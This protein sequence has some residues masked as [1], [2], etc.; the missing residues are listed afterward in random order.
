ML[1]ISRGERLFVFG[2]LAYTGYDVSQRSLTMV[3][4]LM[5]VIVQAKDYQRCLNPENED[6]AHILATPPSDG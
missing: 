2:R 5:P 4:D 6:V 1:A 3:H